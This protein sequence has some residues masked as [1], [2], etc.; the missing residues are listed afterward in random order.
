[1]LALIKEAFKLVWAITIC[2][3]LLTIAIYGV[4]Q[5]WPIAFL[6]G[7]LMLAQFVKAPF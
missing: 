5:C 3:G 6:I 7:I 1:M 4:G 2:L